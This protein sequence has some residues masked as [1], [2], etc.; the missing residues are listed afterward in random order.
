MDQM[1]VRLKAQQ[2]LEEL[3][4][5]TEE[6]VH[7]VVLDDWKVVYINKNRDLNQYKSILK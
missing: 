4:N 7:L 2:I 3:S 5:L 6:T 1:E